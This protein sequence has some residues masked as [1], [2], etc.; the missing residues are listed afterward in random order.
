MQ[1]SRRLKKGDIV[2]ESAPAASSILSKEGRAVLSKHVKVIR[3]LCFINDA[4]FK[5]LVEKHEL[6]V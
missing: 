3:F 5:N 1:A 2:D 4:D 6:N